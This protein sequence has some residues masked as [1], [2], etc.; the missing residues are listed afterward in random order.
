M[1]AK[2]GTQ[3]KKAVKAKAGKTVVAVAKP[4]AGQ[5]LAEDKA[6]AEVKIPKKRGPHGPRKPKE[7]S[8]ATKIHV[9][10]LISKRMKMRGLSKNKLAKTLKLT[11]PTVSLMVNSNSVQTERLMEVS[12]VLGYNFFNEIGQMLILG[13]NNVNQADDMEEL[14]SLSGLK[15]D[16]EYE[17]RFLREENAYLKRIVELMAGGQK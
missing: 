15:G 2:I 12:A 14:H 4:L 13:T 11:P 5:K 10:Q 17:L 3:K 1:K 7:P 9:G 6:Q 16:Q 8:E